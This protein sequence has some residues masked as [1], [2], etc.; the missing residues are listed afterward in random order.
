MEKVTERRH[1]IDAL[2]VLAF[3]LL[4][5]YHQGMAYVAEWGWHVKSVHQSEALQL[6]MLAVNQWRM[7]LLFLIS[8]AATYF[9]FRKLGS[10]RFLMRRLRQLLIPLVFGML[11]IVPPQAYYEALSN[12]VIEPGYLNFLWDYFSFRPWP[13]DSFAG[14]HIGITWNHLWYL[15]YLLCYTLA[16]IPVA[17]LLQTVWGSLESW[18]SGI[19]AWQ[20]LLLPLLPL[21]L[22]GLYLFPLFGGI[23]HSVVGD[24]YT[25]AQFFTFFL[26]GYLLVSVEAP[27]GL[28]KRLRI[29]LLVA[30][31]LSFGLYLL[32]NRVLEDGSFAGQTRINLIIIYANRWLW[33]LAVLAWGYHY[34]NRPF[35]WLPYATEAVYPWYIL[36]QTITVTAIFEL[37]SLPLGPVIEPLLVFT[38]TVVGCLIIHELLVRRQP[39]LRVLFGLKPMK[40][41]SARNTSP[42]AQSASPH[43][44]SGSPPST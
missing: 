3:A 29:Y 43:L 26:I 40:P 42:Q 44:D 16:V 39:L 38:I 10:G 14:S 35:T 27:W 8:G 13:A 36:H 1:D 30:A 21:T 20:L 15:P 33:L 23:N 12:G 22:Y 25:H 31:P 28:L 19:Q 9:L 18:V 17:W 6:A 7:P 2:R 24:W 11:V 32:F 37:G 34:L 5:L 41:S 4:I